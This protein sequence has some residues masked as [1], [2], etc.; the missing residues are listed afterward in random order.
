MKKNQALVVVDVQNDFLEKGA[1]PVPAAS[2]V[3]PVINK[4]APL[5]DT[6][7]FTQDWHPLLLLSMRA[8]AFMSSLTYLTGNRFYGRI[9]AFRK[10]S[11]LSL[12]RDSI[13]VGVPLI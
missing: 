7:V 3:V 13:Q 9:T 12:P 11:D 8:A 2:E 1:L 6:V 5:F 4:I 10:R